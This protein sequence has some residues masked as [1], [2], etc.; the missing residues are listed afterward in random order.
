MDVFTSR[1]IDDIGEMDACVDLLGDERIR[2]EFQV[3]LKQFLATL[4]LV[5][6]RPEALPFVRDAKALAFI[7]AR[8]R[9]RY[10]GAERPIGR[11]VGEKVRKL[12]DDHVVSLGID[13]KIPPIAITDAQ[14][15]EHV[16]R[17]VS[18]RAKASE[19][20]HALRYHIRKHL[21]EDP[22]HYQMLSERL[23]G[24]LEELKGRWDELVEALKK[25]VAEATAGR[26]GDHTG[27][28]PVTQT[29]FLAVIRRA[30][31]GDAGVEGEALSR[32][33]RLTVDLVK[34]IQQE[35]RLVGFWLNAHAQEV[36]RSW[37]VR[38]L[39]GDNSLHVQVVPFE[40]QPELADRMMELAKA[41]HVR[42]AK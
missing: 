26:Q 3:K 32:L 40:R 8:A 33:C 34:H 19:M 41:N 37:I 12:I 21:D 2:A 23:K 36:L 6:P 16:E 28:D 4:D 14:F 22:E 35:V 11:D 24:I 20:E 30:V 27:L 13:P 38:F 29:P 1:D 42:L 7:H 25:L 39:D 18:P 5:L 10:R 15:E 31:A 9:N 17:E